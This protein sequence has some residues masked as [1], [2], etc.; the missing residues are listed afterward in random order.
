MS[1]TILLHV[2]TLQLLRAYRISHTSISQTSTM[3]YVTS[4]KNKFIKCRVL[5]DTCATANFI[6]ESI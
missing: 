1:L 2:F 5:L 6:S 4:H 3:I